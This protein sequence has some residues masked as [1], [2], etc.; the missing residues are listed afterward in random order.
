MPFIT[1]AD[2]LYSI[3]NEHIDAQHK[4]LVGL[5]NRMHEAVVVGSEQ[6]VLGQILEELID[7][8]VYH[9]R[10]EEELFTKHDYPQFEIHRQQ[11]NALTEQVLKLK[12]EF[13]EGSATIS[14]EVLDFI[15]DWLTNHMA[16]S[17]RGFLYFMESKS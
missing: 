11:H 6:S 7:Y 14:Y 1:W 9:F 16:S 17:D 12:T 2:E 13:E 3:K 4:H 5:V 8:T 15:H 10:S